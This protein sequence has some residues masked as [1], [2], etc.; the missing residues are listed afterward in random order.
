MGAGRFLPKLVFI[1]FLPKRKIA[2]AAQSVRIPCE[3][4]VFSPLARPPISPPVWSLTDIE[5]PEKA[6]EIPLPSPP[7]PPP[8][9]V[10]AFRAALPS[11]EFD[12]ALRAR[13]PSAAAAAAAASDPRQYT[14]VVYTRARVR[15]IMTM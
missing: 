2:C 5:F 1:L 4:R 7:P 14:H 3:Q 9:L 10:V 15:S 13:D 12:G 8:R 11:H 6:R